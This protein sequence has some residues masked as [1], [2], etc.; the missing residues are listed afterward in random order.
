MQAAPKA[1]HKFYRKA[2]IAVH[3]ILIWADRWKNQTCS[4]SIPRMLV[5][6]FPQINLWTPL[7]LVSIVIMMLQCFLLVSL[8]VPI[9]IAVH[10]MVTLH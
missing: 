2:C 7:F 3:C 5:I 8:K 10:V 1:V 6:G 4:L 9:I